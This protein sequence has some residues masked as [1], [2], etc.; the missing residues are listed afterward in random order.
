[1]NKKFEIVELTPSGLQKCASFWDDINDTRLTDRQTFVYKM[2]G[3]CVGGCALFE[4]YEKCGHFSHF[5]VR[6][7]LRGKG[8]G[9]KLIEFAINYF[10]EAGMEIM[11]LHVD[12]N[13]PSAIRLYERYSFKRAENITPEKFIMIKIL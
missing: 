9:S 11:R 6:S 12:E 7:D 8:I 4:R 13:N 5:V 2:G 10:K 1:M 3:E